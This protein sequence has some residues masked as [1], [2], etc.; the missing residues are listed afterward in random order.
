MEKDP[1]SWLYHAKEMRDYSTHVG[2]V[3]R[4]FHWGGANDG[5]V[6]LKNPKTLQDVTK[7]FTDEFKEW[8]NNMSL[9]L[10]RLRVSALASY[11]SN[12]AGNS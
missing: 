4:S 9:L 2:G 11:R 5:K 7:H 10:D 1:N 8:L 6:F 12:K 3:P